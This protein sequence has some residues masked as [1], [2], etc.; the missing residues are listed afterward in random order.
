M[1]IRDSSVCVPSIALGYSI[2][3]KGISKD[4]KMPDYTLIDYRN[5]KKQNELLEKYKML[6]QN[7][8]YIRK[9]LEDEI[10]D[11]IQKAYDAK[12][13]I[14]RLGAYNDKN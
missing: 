7:E 5:L 13:C 1:C 2:K 10:Q 9:I 4:L 6:Q 11:Y 12:E 8:H 14:L 3:S